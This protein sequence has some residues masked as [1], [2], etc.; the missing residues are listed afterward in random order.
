[1]DAPGDLFPLLSDAH[2]RRRLLLRLFLIS[3]AA[4]L[5]CPICIQWDLSITR[6]L[7]TE[8]VPGDMRKAVEL[9]EAF[10]H[11]V[12][13]WLILWAI[14][15]LSPPRR[16]GLLRIATLAYGGGAVATLTKLFVIRARPYRIDLE[17]IAPMEIYQWTWD[18]R[19]MHLTTYDAGWRSFPSGHAATAVGLA[20]GLSLLFPRGRPLFILMAVLS[21]VQRITDMAHFPSDVLAGVAIGAAW[22][23][24]C[25][26]PKLLGGILQK[27]EPTPT[28]ET[29]LPLPTATPE[30]DQRRAA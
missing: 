27:I 28:P 4:A 3:L 10:A 23:M 6:W 17:T 21:M 25:I 9:S 29:V 8:E 2:R 15:I 26:H 13:V 18:F 20:V 22:S 5:A 14:A 24:I 19:L 30:Q 7:S 1:M 16:W 11:G 12:G